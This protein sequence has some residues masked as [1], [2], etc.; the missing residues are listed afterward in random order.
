[1]DLPLY[2][3]DDDPWII[4]QKIFDLLNGYLQPNSLSQRAQTADWSCDVT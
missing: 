4:E 1:M 2:L 3:N